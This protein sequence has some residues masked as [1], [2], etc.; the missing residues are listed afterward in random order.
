MRT[1]G[2]LLVI[3]ALAVV[4]WLSGAYKHPCSFAAT[5]STSCTGSAPV[6]V[7]PAGARR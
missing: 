7:A 4:V 2:G 5:A 1:I 6:T 3:A